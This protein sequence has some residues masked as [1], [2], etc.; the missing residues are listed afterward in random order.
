L[1]A[2]GGAPARIIPLAD[3]AQSPGWDAMLH[4][5]IQ[6]DPADASRLLMYNEGNDKR[7]RGLTPVMSIAM[8]G[9]NRKALFGVARFHQGRYETTPEDVLVS[10]D[11]RFALT[12]DIRGIHLIEFAAPRSYPDTLVT[13]PGDRKG[14]KAR[15]VSRVGRDFIG[16]APD[17]QSFFFTTAHTVFTCRVADI[18]MSR[19]GEVCPVRRIDLKIR[20]PRDR[21][22]GTVALRGGRIVTLRGDQV[23]ENGTILVRGNRIAAVGSRAAVAIPAGARVIDVSGKTIVPG[24]ADIH[25]HVMQNMVA[26]GVH[27][28]APFTLLAHLAYGVTTIRDNTGDSDLMT[29]QDRIA[30]GD[31]VGPR[32]SQTVGYIESVRRSPGYE[33]VRDYMQRFGSEFYDAQTIK[34]Y[35]SGNRRIRQWIAM[36]SAEFRLNPTNE[37]NMS[38]AY[39]YVLDGYSGTEHAYNFPSPIYGDVTRFLAESG[40]TYDPTLLPMYGRVSGTYFYRKNNVHGE[41]KLRRFLPHSVLDE[42]SSNYG[43]GT[44]WY[45]D[46]EYLF[47][48]LANDMKKIVEAG[49]RV[50]MGAHGDLPGLGSHF[51]LWALASGGMKPIDVLRVGSYFG[52]DAIGWGKELGTLEV[53]K[54]ADLLVLERN[55]L[56]NIRNTN[57]VRQVMKN[58]RLYDAETLDEIWP[59]QRKLPPLWWHQRDRFETTH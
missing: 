35:V 41:S 16:W 48:Q 15:R 11:G 42:M 29:Y 50:A 28:P 7:G 43:N 37:G 59:R 20:V 25:A 33:D 4:S 19:S 54:L 51:E 57:S 58:G 22:S 55:P 10:P 34:Q 44:D 18:D 36:A 39:T 12:N 40:F 47:A 31:V 3:Y 14:A 1:A 17:G 27:E 21:P 49:G 5:A 56:V 6:F 30:T 46:D 8:D 13:D 52:L 45:R 23:I 38:N 53:G 24:L 2:T 26:T 32:F 9:S